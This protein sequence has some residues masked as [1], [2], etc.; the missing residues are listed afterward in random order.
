MKYPIH[1]FRNNAYHYSAALRRVFLRKFYGMKIGD[2]TR[3]SKTARL[4]RTNPKGVHIGDNTS[5]AYNV[6]VLTHDFV[7]GVHVDTFIGDN[8][9]IG[10]GS[11][12]L[13]GVRVGDNCVIGAASVVMNDIPS[14][15]VA[16]G[17][18]ARLIRS[19]IT[20]K[21]YGILVKNEDDQLD[22]HTD[23]VNT[24][25]E[26]RINEQA[27]VDFI[28][29]ETAVDD[30]SMN[31]PVAQTSVDSFALISLRSAIETKFNLVIP[32]IEWINAKSLAEIAS[33]PSIRQAGKITTRP[34]LQPDTRPDAIRLLQPVSAKAPKP[35]SEG[36]NEPT[37][38]LQGIRV[39]QPGVATGTY[40]IDM[41]Q[42]ALSGLSESW[43]LKEAG[44]THW[45][46]IADFLGQN[47]SAIS[48][49]AGDRLYATFTRLSWR[50][51]SHLRNVKENDS[52]HTSA[53]LKRYGASFFFS[54]Q[55]LQTTS[56]KIDITMM[57]TFAK[58]GERGSNTSLSKGAPT[59]RNPD[60]IPAYDELPEFGVQYRAARAAPVADAMPDT[61][62]ETEYNLLSPHDINGVG[63]LYFAAYPMIFDL[64]LEE[65]EGTGFNL[66]HSSV[67][68]D[69][70][71]FANAEP[72][73]T[74]VFRI[75]RES[76]SDEIFEYTCSLSRKSDNQLMA[77]VTSYKA[78]IPQRG[79]ENNFTPLRRNLAAAKTAVNSETRKTAA[80]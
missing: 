29:S 63:L 49:D 41:P 74:L 46:M 32:D 37:E 26:I 61:L 76:K 48:D 44:N 54:E 52:L 58:H 65:Y 1:K 77:Q 27:L 8:C 75:H 36:A 62:F 6:V 71:Y 28:K 64:C 68:K 10:G 9:F 50:A 79:V 53:T 51:S 23:L 18:P 7:N 45:K 39:I 38:P 3:I 47:S 13:P 12:I 19:G 21:E 24:P 11:T 17:N 69:L 33:L 57:S 15:T 22:T 30:T 59:L 80:S 72:T 70:Y 4:D 78:I 16:A 35:Q 66:A 42:M 5:I 43:M 40:S 73:E 20:T 67:G 60:A 55:Q 31:I 34:K 25:K 2:N 56:E 14:N